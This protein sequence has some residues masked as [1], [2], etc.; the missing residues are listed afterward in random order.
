MVYLN[1]DSRHDIPIPTN[2]GVPRKLAQGYVG[3]VR[4]LQRTGRLVYKLR[5]T[6]DHTR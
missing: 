1:L 5:S 2:A 3:P 4:V 6:M